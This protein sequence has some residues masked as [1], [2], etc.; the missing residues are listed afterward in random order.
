MGP[1]QK[2]KELYPEDEEEEQITETEEE[3]E[4]QITETYEDEEEEQITET[5]EDE[6]EEQITETDEDE[7]DVEPLPKYWVEGKR[8]IKWSKPWQTHQKIE[9]PTI[10]VEEVVGR[11]PKWA[12]PWQKHKE[13]YPE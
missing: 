12:I 5:Y 13:L 7:E 3:E 10:H 9:E 6:E 11:H 2:H 1:W 4:E 8:D